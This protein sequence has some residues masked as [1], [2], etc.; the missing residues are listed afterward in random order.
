MQRL[1]ELPTG[2]GKTKR[3]LDLL[4]EARHILVIVPKL[5]LIKT[6]QDEIGKWGHDHRFFVFSTYQGLEKNVG[7]YDAIVC[8]EC[9]HV[10]ERVAFLLKRCEAKD[11]YFLSATVPWQ[12]RRRIEFVCPQLQVE[13]KRLKDAI[14]EGKLPM[15]KMIYIP[16]KA[17]DEEMGFYRKMSQDVETKKNAYFYSKEQWRKTAWLKAAGDRLK[18]LSREKEE[19]VM[20][21]MQHYAGMKTLTFCCDIPQTERLGEACIHSKKKRDTNNDCL[22]QFDNGTI[23]HL[24]ACATLDEGVNLTGC[25]VGIFAYLGASELKQVQRIGRILRHPEP[26]ILVPY[27]M[28]TREEEIVKK[29]KD[30]LQVG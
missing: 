29:L 12:A 7:S 23:K 4:G 20:R 10:T 8:D 21:V 27:Y 16:L 25:Q 19:A 30:N 15:P 5:V 3:C 26:V 1:I 9:H 6:W 22:K 18:W 14:G 28:G 17:S 24:A 13:R 2:A 11:W